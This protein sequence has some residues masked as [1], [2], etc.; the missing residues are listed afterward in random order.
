MTPPEQ[1]SE[2]A[3][4]AVQRRRRFPLVWL[5]PVLAVAVAAYLGYTT[6]SGRGALIELSFASA[7]GLTAGQTAVRYKAVQIGTV[8][9]IDLDHDLKRV[10]ARIRMNRDVTDRL[11]DKASFWVVR[12]RLTPASVTGLETIVSGSYIEFDPGA[13]GGE[14]RRSFTGLDDP[15]GIRS[16]QP[17]RLFT[18]RARRLGSLDS[19]SPV[20]FRDVQVGQVVSHD[21]PRI[22]GSIDLK[23]FVN[24]PYDKYLH[25]GSR[26]WN[27]S[28]VNLS[29]G[30]QGVKLE[31]ESVR[32]LLAGGVAFDTPPLAL[33][34]P[35]AA[36]DATFELYDDAE[37]AAAATSRDRLSFLIYFDGSVRG[38]AAGSPVEMRGIRIGS[39]TDVQLEY[40][41]E[42]RSF[43]VPVRIAIEPE[44]ISYP[45]GRGQEQ[46]LA[47]SRIMVERGLRA[48]LASGNL[49]TGQK[50]VALD[51][52]T[53]PPP[54]EVSMQGDEIVLPALPGGA[55]I[56]A[57]V[58][59]L[60]GRIERFPLDEI[61]QNLNKTLASL[62]GVVG[63]EDTRKAVGALSSTLRDVQELVR[64][65]DRGLAPLLG[66]L[67][68]IATNLD[69]AVARARSA[70][71][72]VEGGY[73]QG[74]DFSRD[75]SR[76]MSQLT[77]T[78]RSV[79]ILADFLDRH[80][81][82]L[83]RGRATTGDR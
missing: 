30:P 80:P 24:E 74:S 71:G 36:N 33:A 55:D 73:G 39:V 34:Q 53:D 66:K 32:A 6:L 70:I 37:T 10:H 67:P 43:R 77:D 28:G 57:T 76:M 27:A 42:Q 81:E 26:F 54:A 62:N 72:S 52:M 8:E 83:V 40:A 4:E 64:N 45:T 21:R 82:A 48:Q 3:D 17:G 31:L 14:S 75:L 65:A 78:A 2:N 16:D 46:V 11:T 51:F 35:V 58:A 50:V 25:D 59:G 9:T 69:Q 5:V 23:V 61:G 1:L 49:L 19:G 7:D 68:A 60:A 63:S 29:F 20:F 15:P 18:L 22:D 56:M 13:E 12:A 47:L 41:R 44:L 79:R 38:L